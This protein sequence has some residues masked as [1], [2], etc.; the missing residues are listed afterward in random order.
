MTR[1]QVEELFA[2]RDAAA[3]Q[4]DVA[5]ISALNSDDVVVSSPMAGGTIHGRAAVD[6]V[7][8]AYFAGFP[9]VTFTRETLVIDG[10]HAVWI[11][12]VRGTD[13]GGF[14]GLPATGKPFHLPMVM[15]CTLKD[16]V[17]I[18]EQ[19]IY[20]FTGMLIQIGV[21]KAKPI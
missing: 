12:E 13:T 10:D 6:E 2:R 18:R 4:H 1:Q 7:N 16:G 3:N 14:M 8:G 17:I 15:V 19:R 21:L 20:D 5:S 9:D 11:G